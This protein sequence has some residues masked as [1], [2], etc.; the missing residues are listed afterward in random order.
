MGRFQVVITDCDHSAIEEEMEEFAGIGIE[1]VLMQIQ[2]E[3][4]VIRECR[5]ADGLII[6]YAILNRNV[7][8]NQKS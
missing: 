4:D 3:E 5:D 8:E 6:Q 1:P 2:R 7:L